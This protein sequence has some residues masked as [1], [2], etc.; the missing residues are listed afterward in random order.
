MILRIQNCQFHC[1]STIPGRRHPDRTHALNCITL[2]DIIRF[3]S[4]ECF[5][6]ETG[7]ISF[8]D[9]FQPLFIFPRYKQFCNLRCFQTRNIVNRYQLTNISI[10]FTSRSL[11]LQLVF[12]CLYLF[13]HNIIQQATGKAA[14]N[15]HIHAGRCHCSFYQRC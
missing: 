3:V 11:T 15:R 12:S 2:L 1:S 10:C 7:Q 6:I 8:S 5:R 9:R 13:S 14:S 4:T